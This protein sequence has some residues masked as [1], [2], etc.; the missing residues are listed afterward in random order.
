MAGKLSVKNQIR[1]F[2]RQNHVVMSLALEE[3]SKDILMIS[4]IRV[5]L[6]SG[7][8]QKSGRYDKAGALDFR[9]TYNTEY[10]SYQERG[11]RTDGSHRV[12]NYTTPNT[13][14]DFLK[15]AG[16]SVKT[17]LLNYA[18]KAVKQIKL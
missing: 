1:E 4:K 14:K 2:Q 11:V 3:I 5:P 12:Q 7:D 16:E 15:G 13:G 9:V 6:K 18:K 17:N 8:L 10:A